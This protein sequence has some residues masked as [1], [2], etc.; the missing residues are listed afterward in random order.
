MHIPPHVP[1]CH[2]GSCT[3]ARNIP[4]PS[5]IQSYYYFSSL[6]LT[7]TWMEDSPSTMSKV[8][9]Q[10]NSWFV[11]YSMPTIDI[12]TYS[13][14]LRN[15]VELHIKKIGWVELVGLSQMGAEAVVGGHCPHPPRHLPNLQIHNHLN[16][17]R[18]PFPKLSHRLVKYSCLTS[19]WWSD[20]YV[21]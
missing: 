14:H 9:W 17:N 10:K 8:E 18:P 16:Q 20:I 15:L 11:F 21:W 13:F 2:V 19:D 5:Q 3:Q 12:A 6:V 7:I 4:G 1:V